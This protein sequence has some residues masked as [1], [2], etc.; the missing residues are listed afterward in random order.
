MKEKSYNERKTTENAASEMRRTS[1][2]GAEFF[3]ID[4]LSAFRAVAL[5]HVGRALSTNPG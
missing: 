3:Q 2:G 5:L 4:D 1:S